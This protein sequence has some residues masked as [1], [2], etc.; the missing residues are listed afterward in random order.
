MAN[1]L[2][3]GVALPE[4]G[5]DTTTR[6]ITDSWAQIQQAASLCVH[7]TR[8]QLGDTKTFTHETYGEVVMQ[9]V[10]FDADDKSDGSGKAAISWASRD[11]ITTHVMNSTNTSVGGWESSEM[12]SWLQGDFYAAL[13]AEVKA[14]IINVEKTYYNWT[15]TQT[16]YK[17]C[18][19]NLWIPSHREVFKPG[20]EEAG[21]TYTDF[22]RN[23]SARVKYN[24]TGTAS[25]WW[26]RS[27]CGS[28]DC[29]YPVN[30]YGNDDS[31][32][33]GIPNIADGVV[34][35]FCTDASDTASAPIDPTSMLMGYRVG[36]MIR[37]MRVK[38]EP[39]AYLYGHVAKEGETPTHTIDGVGYVGAV[40]PKL[41]DYDAEEY[42]KAFVSY[43]GNYN[44]AGDDL[45][46]LFVSNK[47][48]ST[49]NSYLQVTGHLYGY[50]ETDG[51]FYDK[52]LS[53]YIA[54]RYFVWSN[55]DL[56]VKGTVTLAAS[57]PIPVYE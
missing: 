15:G 10:A 6:E 41:P 46:Q 43:I 26:L 23:D 18:T 28:W 3:K 1:Y 21:A 24:S 30:S 35:G 37:G 2:S 50:S 32:R 38:K 44:A 20:M 5:V 54:H 17:S 22:F 53:D 8:Y 34:L 13:P 29:F 51:W 45:Y 56:V 33:G 27:C 19:D 52:A 42:D 14:A 11:I 31:Y 49:S 47:S 16:E 36:Q 48:A 12:R 9:I 55:V 57:D 39:V 25:S 4:S 7:T 40:L